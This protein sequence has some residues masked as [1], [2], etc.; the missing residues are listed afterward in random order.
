MLNE[1]H[2]KQVHGSSG[3]E[4]IGPVRSL[5]VGRSAWQNAAEERLLTM[6]APAKELTKNA[7]LKQPVTGGIPTQPAATL[8]V[9]VG[10][11]GQLG[12][13]TSALLS[14]S[15]FNAAQLD[16]PDGRVPCTSIPAVICEAMRTRPLKNLGMKVAYETPI[17][18]FQL[19]DYLIVTCENVR[20]AAKQLARYLRIS[21]APFAIEIRDDENP[22]RIVYANVREPFTAEFEIALAIFHFR[23]ETESCFRADYASF[24]HT[25]DDVSEME[26]VLGCPIRVQSQWLGFALS[27][28]AWELPL[29]RQDPVL[30]SI[31]YRN[32][33]ELAARLPETDSV[34]A[35]L[36][37]LLITRMARGDS[38][39]QFVAR[40]MATSVRSLQ[41]RLAA[42]GTSYQKILDSTRREAAGR[43]VSNCALSISEVGYLLGYSEPAA[44]HRAFKRWYGL[45]PY[46]FR[47]ARPRCHRSPQPFN[48]QT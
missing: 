14:A 34:V 39:I 18:A 43:H 12:Y 30:H 42:A 17:G 25:P 2:W 38:D 24:T 13:D 36:R 40:S 23:R 11:L 4:V 1:D 45:T 37:R 47:V 28:E 21:E 9:F 35:E 20:E 8:R 48:V 3:I 41:R 16:D 15:G 31:L 10:A 6:T 22:I 32:A 44:F 19:L 7:K 27:R 29:R 26:Q 5:E 33:E 46:E